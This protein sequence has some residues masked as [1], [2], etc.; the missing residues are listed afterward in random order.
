M[1]E[2]TAR[3]SFFKGGVLCLSSG[4]IVAVEGKRFPVA[5]RELL[6]NPGDMSVGGISGEGESGGR[7]RMNEGN[8]SGED[9]L[10]SL[11]GGGTGRTPSESLGGAS[12]SISERLKDTGGMRDKTVVEI[13]EAEETLEIFISGGRRESE[14]G[15]HVAGKGFEAGGRDGVTKE[16][17]G[18]GSS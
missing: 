2:K 10:S 6:E 3:S 14:N 12:E 7:I 16:S 13:H 4:E 15:I 17:V 1:A 5:V 11:E 9:R 18:L 8:C